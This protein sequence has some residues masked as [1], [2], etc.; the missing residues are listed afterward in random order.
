MD[1]R[2][3]NPLRFEIGQR[4]HLSDVNG[5]ETDIR[6]VVVTGQFSL[7]EYTDPRPYRAEP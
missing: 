7:I 6:F 1:G 3:A 4:M 5:V 2:V